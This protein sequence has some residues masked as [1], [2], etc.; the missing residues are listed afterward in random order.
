MNKDYIEIILNE[1]HEELQ[2][3]WKK[4]KHN[5]KYTCI[6]YMPIEKNILRCLELQEFLEEELK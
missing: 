4:N 6:G 2:K 3:I 5:E 1:L